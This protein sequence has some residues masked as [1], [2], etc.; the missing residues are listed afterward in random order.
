MS[1]S[2]VGYLPRCADRL[3]H[4]L[5]S[6]PEVVA[7]R[8]RVCARAITIAPIA[9]RIAGGD[10]L[11]DGFSHDA[12]GSLGAVAHPVTA[13]VGGDDLAHLVMSR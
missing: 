6:P 3:Y 2:S 10:E 4:D 8:E 12:F 7:V 5:F 11:I 13:D 9:H 1:T